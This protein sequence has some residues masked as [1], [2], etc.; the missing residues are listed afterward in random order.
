MMATRS[1]HEA[2]AASSRSLVIDSLMVEIII[3]G[4]MV[5]FVLVSCC[6]LLV[7][8]LEVV[9]CCCCWRGAARRAEGGA[10]RKK[11]CI[12][13]YGCVFCM[14]IFLARRHCQR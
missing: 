8:A 2:E 6:Y 12:T 10:R 11:G 9:G 7:V 4:G 1:L 3:F 13:C 5:D 14:R